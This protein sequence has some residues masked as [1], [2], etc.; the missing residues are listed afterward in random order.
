MRVSVIL[1]T[2]NQPDALE[3]VLWG[4]A[5]QTRRDFELLV[6]DDGSGPATAEVIRRVR[7]Q[8]GL[9]VT[10]VWHE[11]QGFRKCEILNRAI[12]ASSGDYLIFSDGD[13]IP[14]ADFVAAHVEHAAPGHFLA[15]GCVRVP[16]GVTQL[17]TPDD[18]RSGRFADPRW[19]WE[20]GWRPGHRLLRLTRS[21][22][23]AHL[24]DR[25]T[26]TRAQFS[27]HNASTWRDAIVAANGF[28]CEMGY[29]G[30]DRALGYRLKNL[31]LRGRKV[32]FRAVCVHL[33]HGHPYR[34]EAVV[35]RNRAILSRIV[36]EREVRA[37]IGL[38]EIAAERVVEAR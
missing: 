8:S 27:G 24:L 22:P 38:E 20:R 6:A 34:D 32:R 12:L 1:S 4:Y 21:R 23:L 36:R 15:G 10:H 33:H 26:P 37:R 19:L 31:G 13:C 5:L 2:Y 29:G 7:E 18:V 14:R 3:R 16:A 11:D 28:E 25:L 30:L 17:I 35:R 9:D